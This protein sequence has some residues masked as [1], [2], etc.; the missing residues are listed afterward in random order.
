M[1]SN[2]SQGH[3][4]GPGQDPSQRAIPLQNLSRDESDDFENTDD[5]RGRRRSSGAR[6]GHGPRRS[7]LTGGTFK[8]YERVAEDSPSPKDRVGLRIT[9]P[10]SARLRENNPYAPDDHDFVDDPG[11]FAEAMGSIG[12]GF[13]PPSPRRP[14]SEEYM[15]SSFP[16]PSGH[17]GRATPDDYFSS[18]IVPV[19]DTAPL[20]DKKYLQPI[21]GAKEGDSE[22]RTSMQSIRLGNSYSS[23]RLGD[24]L[25]TGA[26]RRRGSGSAG[27]SPSRSRSL[28][29]S[30]SGSALHRAGTVMRMMSQ[31][32]V[33][34]S[35]EPV[36]QAIMR[37]ESMK[38]SKQDEP[39]SS[40]SQHESDNIPHRM[41]SVSE[42]GSTQTAW[43]TN[44]NPFKGK[45]LG[46]F[47]PDNPL[48]TKL[49][50]VLVHPATEPFILLVIVV[51]AVLLT[52]QSA[53]SV[54]THPRSDQWGSQAIDYALFVI[55]V[56][57]TVELSVRIIVSG[58]IWNSAEY[59]TM[60][61]SLGFK[62]AIAQR[63]KSLLSLQR[64]PS[65]KK[66]SVKFE[67]AQPSYLRKTVTG[68]QPFTDSSDDPRHGSRKRLAYR[69]F[70][71][72]SFNRLDF[73]AVISYWIS[74]GLQITG[75]SSKHNIY[76]FQMLSCLRLLRLLGITD[77]TS[78][79]QCI[80]IILH[81][82]NI[83]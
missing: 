57:Y 71:R 76:I 70:L 83:V 7:L 59:S 34:L 51:H 21:S 35:N 1:A 81:R 64:E 23:S 26:G 25:E 48:R 16:G 22:G 66:K 43:R 3:V 31:R 55:F 73:L 75:Y 80:Y 8:T 17:G 5:R 42:K 63:G 68:L 36:E 60:D 29:P 67:D 18:P 15:M 24:D 20:T 56:I 27:G 82:S 47:S 79:R 12:F 45:S 28:S 49:C 6:T 38:R 52:V 30:V 77:G 37:R 74:F 32:V 72:H 14:D 19:D 53:H 78:V 50:D 33:N 2:N 58:F 40:P 54:W 9:Q 4:P 65:T 69:A 13:R 10:S 44:V 41:E 61:R 62:K 39:P 46:I 11:G